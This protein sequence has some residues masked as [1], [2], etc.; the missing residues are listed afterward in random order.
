MPLTHGFQEEKKSGSGVGRTPLISEP[1]S[2]AYHAHAHMDRKGSAGSNG[3]RTE[4]GRESIS[5][6][7]YICLPDKI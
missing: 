4:R 2:S 1:P 6:H 3:P 5:T 7:Y